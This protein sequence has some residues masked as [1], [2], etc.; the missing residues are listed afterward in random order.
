MVDKNQIQLI[1]YL[2]VIKTKSPFILG[3]TL[4]FMVIAAIYF[5]GIC[6]PVYEAKTSLLNI[7]AKYQ[8]INTDAT[9][10]SLTMNALKNLI[11]SKDLIAAVR[12]KL[13][14][15]NSVKL[16]DLTK[17]MQVRLLIEEDTNIRKTYA[18]I[19]ELYAQAQTGKEAAL[20]A[21]TWA[22][23]FIQRYNELTREVSSQNFD[24]L[25]TEYATLE[26]QLKAKQSD[27]IQYQEQLNFM[28]RRQD[29][30]RNLVSGYL[31]SS[32]TNSG[33]IPSQNVVDMMREQE[34]K[35]EDYVTM[36]KSRSNI[37][38]DMP[39]TTGL[40]ESNHLIG[41]EGQLQDI[42]LK[43]KELEARKIDTPGELAELSAA[44][45][46]KTELIVKIKSLKKDIEQIKNTVTTLDT[47]VSSLDRE[48]AALQSKY[49]L[50]AKRK[51]E[52]ELEKARLDHMTKSGLIYSEDIKIASYAVAPDK[53]IGPK[54]AIGT[55]V[56]GIIGCILFTLI[57]FIQNYIA[58]ASKPTE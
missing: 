22:E 17:S 21:N 6:K 47:K 56:A 18:P 49:I 32:P 10:N 14:W 19:I 58:L 8:K 50:L 3:G 34:L 7:P 37:N 25:T 36:Y 54:R 43:I 40:L 27:F 44:K 33:N 26:G 4:L 2:R 48:V 39:P 20:L 29:S 45:A 51:E 31:Q 46:R 15:E 5:W 57:A 41:Y 28:K 38:V 12:K 16:D 9:S 42:E 55:L 11:E 1:D 52:A 30:M 53:K 13:G 35:G 23:L 24:F